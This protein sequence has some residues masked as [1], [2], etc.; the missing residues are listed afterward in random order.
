MKNTAPAIFRHDLV[1]DLA[2]AVF[3]HRWLANPCK[4]ALPLTQK[5][6]AWLQSLDREPE[7]ICL[8]PASKRLGHYYEALWGFFFN[9]DPQFTLLAQQLQVNSQGK[10]HGE[11]D[12]I[13]FDHLQQRHLHLEVAIKFYMFA[14]NNLQDAAN[15]CHWLGPNSRD[16]LNKKQQHMQQ[17]QQRLSELPEAKARLYE[18]GIEQITPIMHLQ[19]FLFSQGQTRPSST[20]PNTQISPYFFAHNCHKAFEKTCYRLPKSRWLSQIH[21][22]QGLASIT[23]DEL[24]KQLD[25]RPTP[26]LLCHG[27]INQEG[28]LI[29]SQRFFICPDS[30]PNTA[31]YS[32]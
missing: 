25:K 1:N 13:V 24:L 5:R 11:F 12:F 23:Q 21:Q 8:E 16:N 7:R 4:L 17:Q 27:T 6:L 29:E 20:L 30:W 19:G 9:H 2:S 3:S 22:A 31:V 18:Y 28:L 26:Q 14:G 32:G 15:P 10:T